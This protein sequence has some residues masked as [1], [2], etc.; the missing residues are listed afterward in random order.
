M[1]DTL[2]FAGRLGTLTLLRVP[3]NVE[4]LVEDVEDE[5]VGKSYD[6]IH[7][8]ILSGALKSWTKLIERALNHLNPDGW[9]E[10]VE[11][12]VVFQSNNNSCDRAP[13]L[14]KWTDGL[15]EA[16]AK[17]G[18][19][20]DVAVNLE[21]WLQQAGFTNVV[22]HKMLVPFGPWPKDKE[23][24]IIGAYQ[25]MNMLDATTSY[26]QAHFTRVLGWTPLEYEVFSAKVRNQLQDR[27]L[28]L[29]ADLYVF[30]S[31]CY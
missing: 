17:I 6:Y 22:Q 5:W 28:Q 18:R 4:F 2:V 26:G 21:K 11:F 15:L 30:L 7:I 10:I 19:Q 16:G 1:V 23:L 20:M 25:L 13:E 27:S 3:P 31:S 24:K 8:R 12:E 14:K 29:C 9:L